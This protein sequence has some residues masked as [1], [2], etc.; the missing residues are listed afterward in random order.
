MLTII[1]ILYLGN[2]KQIIN[3]S[4]MSSDDKFILHK[5][6]FAALSLLMYYMASHI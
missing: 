4:N 1:D 5:Y 2:E 3:V 6:L